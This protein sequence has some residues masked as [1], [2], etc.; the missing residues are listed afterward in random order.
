MLQEWVDDGH[1]EVHAIVRCGRDGA[2]VPLSTVLR[3]GE[4]G[5]AYTQAEFIEHYGGTTEWDTAETRKS[6]AA[7]A[8]PPGWFYTDVEDASVLHGPFELSMLQEWVDDGHFEVH[9]I[10]RSGRNGAPVPLS[11]VLR[12]GEDGKAYTQAEFVEHYGG[13]KEWHA[14]AAVAVTAEGDRDSSAEGTSSSEKDG[15]VHAQ[16]WT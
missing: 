3:I 9:A 14:A 5:K 1:F 10:V 2:P 12:I 7:V 13:T 6:E 8:Q 4:N 16:G 11:T 15:E